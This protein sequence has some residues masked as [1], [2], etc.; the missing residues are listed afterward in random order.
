M[1]LVLC[2]P[3]VSFLFRMPFGVPRSDKGLSSYCVAHSGSWNVGA[4]GWVLLPHSQGP[5]LPCF[6]PGDFVADLSSAGNCVLQERKQIPSRLCCA[7]KSWPVLI[8]RL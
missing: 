6:I 5:S 1:S 7:G 2:D 4:A 8:S 3:Q